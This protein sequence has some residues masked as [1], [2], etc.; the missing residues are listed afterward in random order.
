MG[1]IASG[2]YQRAYVKKTADGWALQVL[3]APYGGLIDGKDGQG[4]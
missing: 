1:R 2:P 4:E 3:G